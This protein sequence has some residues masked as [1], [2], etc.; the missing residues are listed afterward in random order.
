[1]PSVDNH[2]PTPTQVKRARI[3]VW[4]TGIVAVASFAGVILGTGVVRALLILFGSLNALIAIAGAYGPY[5]G[6]RK[7]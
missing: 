4:I 5:L 6:N 1:V 2:A 7:T 3:T